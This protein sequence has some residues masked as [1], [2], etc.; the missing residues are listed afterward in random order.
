MANAL[1]NVVDCVDM[2]FTL[3]HLVKVLES[4]AETLEKVVELTWLYA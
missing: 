3:N 2:D 1:E 4:V